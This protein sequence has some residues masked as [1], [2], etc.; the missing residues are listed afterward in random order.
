MTRFLVACRLVLIIPVI[1]CVLLMAGV[2]IMGIGR[3]VTAGVNLVRVGDFSAKASKTMALAVIEI[4]D[5]FLVGTVAYIVAVGLY[6][7]FVSSTQIELPTRLRDR[8]AGVFHAAKQQGGRTGQRRVTE[9]IVMSKD[10][11]DT[12]S[13]WLASTGVN[14]AASQI[15]TDY[16]VYLVFIIGCIIAYF[17]AKKA[18]IIAI[19]TTTKRST[20]KWDDILAKKKFFRT[21]SY[22]IPAF[23]IF[24]FTPL[25]LYNYPRT[26]SAIKTGA[27]IYMVIIVMMAL[28]ALLDAVSQMYQTL[29]IARTR[30]I[31]GY[32]QIVKIIVGLLGAILIVAN[33][34]GKSPMGLIGGLGA[35]SA[36]FLLVFR[37]PI[38]GF[39][40]GIQLTANNMLAP[41][42][43][44][45]MPDYDADGTV[46]DIALTTVKVQNWDKT[47]TTIPTYS[48]MSKSFINWRGM[49]ES[50][51]RRIKRSINIDMKSVKFCT[52]ELLDKFSKIMDVKRYVEKKQKELEIYNAERNIDDSIL[53]NGRRQT[54]LGVFRAYLKGYLQ[55]HP[56]VHKDMT[57]LIRQLQPSEKGLPM[58]VYIF[59]R[60]QEWAK[61]E[62][63]QSDIF[64]HVLAV[65]PEFEL[66]V[67]QN[68]TGDDFGSLRN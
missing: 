30:P 23:I 19:H 10:L 38:L 16:T 58:E 66:R 59:S 55:N 52:P 61:Y 35:F 33:L 32:V 9:E 8:G 67:F 49:Q 31:K 11:R 40:G 63:L 62:D 27:S 17:I 28:N 24:R 45:S 64:D 56:D 39:A 54:N 41:G 18:L 22:L 50:G 6:K 7:L 44:I 20:N 15:I 2:V 14:E 26:T 60:I 65:I 53:V 4:I 43:W 37:D 13:N 25:I 21:I 51:G 29:A 3:I 46:V 1:G 5:L 12:F 57:F 68:P 36:V 47:I 42:D 48:L 34:F